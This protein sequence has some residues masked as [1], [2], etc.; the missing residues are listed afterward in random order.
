MQIT[1]FWSSDLM[2]LHNET[3]N[4]DHSTG[5]KAMSDRRWNTYNMPTNCALIIYAN[6]F[7]ALEL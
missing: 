5:K 4:A 1:S 7:S 6:T 3:E 2:I